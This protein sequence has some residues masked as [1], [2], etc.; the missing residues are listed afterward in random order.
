MGRKIRNGMGQ[1][2][3][4]RMTGQD[5]S[6]MLLGDSRSGG[7]QDACVES[8]EETS[9]KGLMSPVWQQLSRRAQKQKHVRNGR[10]RQ[11]SWVTKQRLGRPAFRE[12]RPFPVLK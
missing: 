11:V 2:E 3:R 5:K 6:D 9:E 1:M 4:R 10:S 12:L 7:E 8:L